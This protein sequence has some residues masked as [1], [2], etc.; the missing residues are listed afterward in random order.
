MT[1]RGGMKVLF[2]APPRI[3]A[4]STSAI[5]LNQPT[6]SL[7]ASITVHL[8]TINPDGTEYHEI[9]DAEVNEKCRRNDIGKDTKLP[10]TNPHST[11]SELPHRQPNTQAQQ[12][13]PSSTQSAPGTQ[14]QQTAD[15]PMYEV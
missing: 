13:T 11:E 9:I 14:Q 15:I 2:V 12:P 7:G 8:V 6:T 5:S 1:G 4:V 3:T 10:E